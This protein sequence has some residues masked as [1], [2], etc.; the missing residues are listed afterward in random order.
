VLAALKEHSCTFRYS[1]VCL[2][3]VVPVSMHYKLCL[4]TVR[5]KVQQNGRLVRFSDRTE[6]SSSFSCSI[7][8]QTAT[9]LGVS[10]VAIPKVMMAY[11]NHGRTASAERNTGRKPK[12]VNQSRYRPGVA[13]RVPGS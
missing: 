3:C 2:C 4:V 12:K 9:S 13:Q 5:M 8:N 6:C 10:R 7:C 1:F 11:T